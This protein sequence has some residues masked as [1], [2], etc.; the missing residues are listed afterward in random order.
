[1][2]NVAAAKMLLMALQV[3]KL[4]MEV[5]PRWVVTG[6]GEEV[7]VEPLH[8]FSTI[9][10]GD[11]IEDWVVPGWVREKLSG[12]TSMSY[13]YLKGAEYLDTTDE[14]VNKMVE[15]LRTLHQELARLD[16]EINA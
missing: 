6:D 1:M 12:L 4:R 13:G 5:T 8:Y 14:N 16:N 2:A 10:G 11:R 3:E 15:W 7:R 9:T